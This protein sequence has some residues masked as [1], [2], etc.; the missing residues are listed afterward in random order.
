MKP[1]SESR[2]GTRLFELGLGE[3]ALACTAASA[4]S[5]QALIGRLLA[6]HGRDGFA[7]AWLESRGV[8]WA[9]N[10]LPLVRDQG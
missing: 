6:E 7:P 2:C 8:A 4:K 1:G 10:L 5:D 9:V 3:V